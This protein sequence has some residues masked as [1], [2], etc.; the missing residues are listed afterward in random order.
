[1]LTWISCP[2][3]PPRPCP[4]REPRGWWPL[5]TPGGSGASGSRWPA[6]PGSFPVWSAGALQRE[7]AGEKAAAHYNPPRQIREERKRICRALRRDLGFRPIS[8]NQYRGYKEDERKEGLWVWKTK[9]MKY[10]VLEKK[11]KPLTL[12]CIFVFLPC[13]VGHFQAVVTHKAG[14]GGGKEET[15]ELWHHHWATSVWNSVLISAVSLTHS[16][17]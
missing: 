11:N 4:R 7:G 2:V 17:N 8:R 14:R 5:R 10:N 9:G 13:L 15:H 12:G 1:M 3:W 16:L 6:S